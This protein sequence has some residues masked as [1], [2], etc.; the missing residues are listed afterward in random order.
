MADKKK[1]LSDKNLKKATG[2]AFAAGE[3]GGHKHGGTPHGPRSGY[4]GNKPIQEASG[5]GVKDPLPGKDPKGH[6]R[7]V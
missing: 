1:E 5:R 3:A 4:V 2:G 7:P 6:I